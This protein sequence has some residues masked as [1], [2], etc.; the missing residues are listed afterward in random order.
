MYVL[1]AMEVLDAVEELKVKLTS[2][3]SKNK[4][5]C[6]YLGVLI[7]FIFVDLQEERISKVI[8]KLSR[9]PMTIEILKVILT[10]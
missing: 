1:L 10:S 6:V 3:V 4:V 8:H 7:S 2:A 9:L 5:V